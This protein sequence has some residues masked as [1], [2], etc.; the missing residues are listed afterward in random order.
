VTDVERIGGA[1]VVTPGAKIVVRRAAERLGRQF[2]REAG[3]D[4]PP[5]LANEPEDQHVVLLPARKYAIAWASL[6]AGAIGV[7]PARQYEGS[8]AR[9]P[10]AAWAYLHPYVRGEGLIERLWPHL[11]ARWPGITLAGPFTV[12]GRALLGRLIEA[13][14]HPTHLNG[15]PVEQLA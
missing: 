12:S 13:G 4:F 3:F 6:Y 7:D 11:G 8:D 14:L 9:V 15:V 1:L 5:Y 10:R 2:Q